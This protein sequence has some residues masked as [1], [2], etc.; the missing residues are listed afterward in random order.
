MVV[1]EREQLARS[2]SDLHTRSKWCCCLASEL[3][4]PFLSLYCNKIIIVPSS[5][6]NPK[7][8]RGCMAR[9][10]KLIVGCF[11][12]LGVKEKSYNF[13]NYFVSFLLVFICL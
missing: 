2:L 7:Y 8:R 11:E 12:N 6:L 9:M 1:T 10:N 5:F 4:F 13:T 3:T